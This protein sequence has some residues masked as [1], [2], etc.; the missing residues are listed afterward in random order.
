MNKPAPQSS[1]LKKRKR[2]TGGRITPPAGDLTFISVPKPPAAAFNKERPIGC[3]IQAQLLHIHHA[4]SARLPKAKRD[5]RRP[6]DIHTEAE[7]ASYIASVTKILRP[8]RFRR[9][10]RF[11]PASS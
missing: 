11:R 3:L 6:E 4:E 1:K 8:Q 7:A 9:R 5:G 2:T 10:P